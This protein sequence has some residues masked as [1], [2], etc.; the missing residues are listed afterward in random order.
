MALY[1]NTWA[2]GW[3]AKALKRPY[4]SLICPLLRST[5]FFCLI[6]RDGHLSFQDA[7]KYSFAH[8]HLYGISLY[9]RY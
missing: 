7:A 4:K 3:T 1:E 2:Q 5:D 6:D 9:E 8:F